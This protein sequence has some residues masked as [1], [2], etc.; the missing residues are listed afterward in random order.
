MK[1]ILCAVLALAAMTSCSKDYTITESKQA[2]AFGEAFVDNGTRAD[3]SDGNNE[4][5]EFLVYGTVKGKYASGAPEVYIFDG[6]PVTRPTG[7]TGYN[8][9]EAWV[10]NNVQYWVPNADYAFTAVVDGELS[11]DHSKIEFTVADGVDNKDLLYATATASVDGDG[12]VTGTNIGTNSLVKFNFDHLLSK[13]QFTITNEML[14]NYHIQVTGITVGGVTDKGVY[15][16]N[17]GT[18]T[19]ATDAAT[20]PS[21]TF[22]TTGDIA[23]NGSAVAS[24]TRQIL[25]VN[26][27]LAVTIAY[28]IYYGDVATGTKISAATKSGTIPAQDYAKETVYNITAAISANQIK[29]TVNSVNGWTNGGDIDL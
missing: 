18:W 22:G 23:S 20:V 8:S 10:C 4:V 21:L 17:G 7:L 3:Y 2:I 1:K 28:D 13:L 19:K 27:T 6:T 15:T 26:Q 25:P 29:F 16:V 5:E 11:T 9:T 14:G 12:T 24:E